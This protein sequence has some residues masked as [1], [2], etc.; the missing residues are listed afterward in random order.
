MDGYKRFTRVQKIKF[1]LDNSYIK[2]STKEYLNSMFYKD[3][4]TEQIDRSI[5]FTDYLKENLNK[6]IAYTEYVAEQ[7]FIQKKI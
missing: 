4:F 1:I 7:N 2:G 6:T 3:F 5:N